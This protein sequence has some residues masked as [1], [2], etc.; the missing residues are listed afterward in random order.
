[1]PEHIKKDVDK[2]ILKS[3]ERSPY[4]AVIGC[5]ESFN[6]FYKDVLS[7]QSDK[8]RSRYFLFS[9]LLLLYAFIKSFLLN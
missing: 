5:R 3:V 2:V 4:S 9:L 7:Y 1:M 8:K 6:R